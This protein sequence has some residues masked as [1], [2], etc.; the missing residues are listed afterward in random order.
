MIRILKADNF[1]SENEP[2]QFN[3]SS[4][5]LYFG[6]MPFLNTVFL[7]P[8]EKRN[9]Q[10]DYDTTVLL[11]PLSGSIC[12]AGSV[13]TESIKPEQ[14]GML[15]LLSGWNYSVQ[16]D[17]ENAP[18]DFLQIGFCFS[19][20]KPDINL[21]ISDIGLEGMNR[22]SPVTSIISG[23]EE[24]HLSLGIFG[25]RQEGEYRLHKPE[26]A[27]ILYVV[28]GSVDAAGCLIEYRDKLLFTSTSS[29][30][31]E[32]LSE[33]VILLFIEL[34]DPAFTQNNCNR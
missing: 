33:N 20:F 24:V 32:A 13:Q 29:V 16:T 12:C 31:F 3:R 7:N 6:I 8:G 1:Q 19:K 25:G 26:N 15:K 22:I 11:L 30:E 14:Y 27:L 34:P 2:E 17:S 9:Y 23:N 21:R 5:N 28:N 4:S 10:T 18:A